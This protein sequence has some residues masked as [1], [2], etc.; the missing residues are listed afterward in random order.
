M[1]HDRLTVTRKGKKICLLSL[2]DLVATK[3]HTCGWEMAI[4][5]SDRERMIHTMANLTLLTRSENSSASDSNFDTKK[6]RLID[7]LF[8]MNIVIAGKPQL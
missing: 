6:A 2:L 4:E 5:I 3:W 7:S 8:R 1:D